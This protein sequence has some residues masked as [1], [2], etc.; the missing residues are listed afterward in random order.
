V[1]RQIATDQLPE[2][3]RF[4][5][6][7][8]SVHAMFGLDAEPLPDAVRPFHGRLVARSL[9][10]LMTCRVEAEGHFI[11]KRPTALGRGS[12]AG[13]RIYHECGP[14]A[15]FRMDTMEG[16]TETGDIVLYDAA[17]PFET[18]PRDG[19]RHDMWV[20][21]K[22]ILAPHL[23]AQSGLLAMVLSGQQGTNALAA[24]YLGALARN[25]DSISETEIGAI[26]DALARLIGVACGAIAASQADAVCAGRL[27]QAK[28][29]I[30]LHL[31]DR[32]LSP[33]IVAAALGI[34]VRTL[35][36][37]FEPSGS[38][39]ARY[40]LRRRLEAC[41][42]ALV[43]SPGRPIIDIAFA[44]GFGSLSSFYSA[45]QAAYG[46]APGE[47]RAARRGKT[48]PS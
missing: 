1:R 7:A 8:E 16:T 12:P 23:P 5:A 37:L 48:L 33:A 18:R 19:Y 13:Y 14:G 17:A 29:Y 4:S 6:W 28:R 47:L 41:H 9:G 22:S 32:D 42:A 24:A 30:D 36:A 45:F 2:K 31:A 27:T 44:W 40:V 21:P 11:A 15:W 43:T 46:M 35:H 34:A 25:W 38:S 26:A 10:P 3:A 20:M 39:F